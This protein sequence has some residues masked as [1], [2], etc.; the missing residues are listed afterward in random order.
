M[1]LFSL[2]GRE[3]AEKAEFLL[4]SCLFVAALPELALCAMSVEYPIVVFAALRKASG[5]SIII[6]YER[7]HSV[8]TR[9]TLWT[10]RS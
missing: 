1:Q 3:T 2:F 10:S 9:S 6:R 8:K 4:S 5:K 7:S